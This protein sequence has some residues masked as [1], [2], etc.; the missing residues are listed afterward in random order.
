[1]IGKTSDDTNHYVYEELDQSI[2]HKWSKDKQNFFVC[3]DTVEEKRE[4]LKWKIEY[5]SNPEAQGEM[6]ALSWSV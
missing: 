3:G 5:S 2:R 6:I 1:M 4:P